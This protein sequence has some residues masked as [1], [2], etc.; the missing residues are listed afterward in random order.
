VTV[1]YPNPGASWGILRD[2]TVYAIHAFL[3]DL[4]TPAQSK[5]VVS[6]Q[7]I[8]RVTLLDASLLRGFAESVDQAYDI[9]DAVKEAA[10]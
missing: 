6:V 5:A 4:A 9:I 1:I 7:G 8:G 2:G 10:V 3:L